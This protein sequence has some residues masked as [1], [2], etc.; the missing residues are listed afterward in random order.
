[1][2]AR[3]TSLSSYKNC[4]IKIMQYGTKGQA[5]CPS[6]EFRQRTCYLFIVFTYEKEFFNSY[7]GTYPPEDITEAIYF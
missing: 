4:I 2:L 1:M 6:G 7:Q 5:R 3:R